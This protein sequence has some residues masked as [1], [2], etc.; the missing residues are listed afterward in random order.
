[1]GH[2]GLSNPLIVE[3]TKMGGFWY[4]WGVWGLVRIMM[5]NLI[6]ILRQLW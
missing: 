2:M 1:M 6:A 3:Q 4:I 5:G